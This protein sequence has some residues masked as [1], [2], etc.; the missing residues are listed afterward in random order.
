MLLDIQDPNI[1]FE[2]GCLYDDK[3][4]GKSCCYVEGK[5][6]HTLTTCAFCGIKNET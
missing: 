1:T 2:E 5:L 6:P 3:V 4:K